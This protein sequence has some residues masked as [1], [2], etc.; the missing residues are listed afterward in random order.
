[1]RENVPVFEKMKLSDEEIIE[2]YLVPARD[3]VQR[4]LTGAPGAVAGAFS[5]RKDTRTVI[6]NRLLAGLAQS[7]RVAPTQAAAA[8]EARK[9]AEPPRA[10]ITNLSTGMKAS[11]SKKSVKKM[12]DESAVWKSASLGAHFAAIANVDKLF[13]VAIRHGQRPGNREED[14]ENIKAIHKFDA[15]MPFNGEV[16]RVRMT[17][18]EF[19]RRDADGDRIYTLEIADVETPVLTGQPTLQVSHV[20]EQSTHWRNARFAQMVQIVKSGVVPP[21]FS[22]S[23]DQT[24]TPAFKKW[25]GNSK[26]V[27][28]NGAPLVVYRGE[29]GKAEGRTAS[30]VPTTGSEPSREEIGY[31]HQFHGRLGSLSFG[32]QE[33]ASTYATY[34]NNRGDEVHSP[35]VYPV[36][37]RIENPIINDQTDP[38]IELGRIRDALGE[39]E[40][41]R[42]AL[43]FAGRIEHTG[44]WIEDL[45]QQ[46]DSV[47]EMLDK[48]PDALRKLYFDAFPYLDDAAEVAKLKAAG[49]D[50]AIHG[51]NGESALEPEY[52]VFSESQVKSAIGNSGAFDAAN[53]DIRFSRSSAAVANPDAPSRFPSFAP[54]RQRMDRV[55]DSLIYN[56]QDRF[57]PL[58]DIQK[59]AAL[60]PESEGFRQSIIVTLPL[61]THRFFI[62][63]QYPH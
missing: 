45:S 56:F 51:G 38:F 22:R 42:I 21:A 40:A 34:P 9:L 44:N 23:A 41:R 6:A 31:G 48:D 10:E 36:Y 60:V 20:H 25:F 54:F 15:P 57:K 29:H 63:R 62:S 43:K 49:Y 30:S 19:L 18:K 58:K 12:M 55:I 16:W 7:M 53:P 14:A 2:R 35:R 59:R 4:G 27:D 46:Y 47:A 8:A 13:E 28:E 11:V 33:V 32:S 39:K 50:G 1:L 17:V 5:R 24:D 37:L 52:K 61:T 26:V 3:F